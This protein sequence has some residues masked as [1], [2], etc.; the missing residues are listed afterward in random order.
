MNE[1]CFDTQK[2]DDNCDLLH[3]KPDQDSKESRDSSKNMESHAL[4]DLILQEVE[5]RIK[6]DS[7]FS[8]I[9]SESTHQGQ[10]KWCEFCR[11]WTNHDM[12][13]CHHRDRFLREG[14]Y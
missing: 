1:C 9:Q 12:R 5:A 7:T 11:I 14:K 2:F 4:V 6:V 8:H 3:G 10:T 13:E